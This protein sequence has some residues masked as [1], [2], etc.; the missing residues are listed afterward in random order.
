MDLEVCEEH[1][2]LIRKFEEYC[3]SDFLSLDGIKC[4][5]EF[6][7]PHHLLYGSNYLHRV[8]L[9]R[10]VTLEMVQYIVTARSFAAS[11]ICDIDDK[12]ISE[13]YPLHSA[14]L[15][16]HCPNSVVELFI[17]RR[18]EGRYELAQECIICWDRNLSK[19]EQLTLGVGH[20]LPL[21]L[22]L[23]RTKNISFNVVKS[24]VTAVPDSLLMCERRKQS[25]MHICMMNSNIRDMFDIVKYLDEMNPVLFST[26]DLLCRYPLHLACKNGNISVEMIQYIIDKWPEG[27]SAY[28]RDHWLPLHY[29]CDS[30]SMSRNKDSVE[31]LK[32]MLS[33]YPEGA[34]QQP[35]DNRDLPFHLAVSS[36][37]LE[38]CN[39]FARAHPEA[40]SKL[41][42]DYHNLPLHCACYHRGNLDVIK[43]LHGLYPQS[44]RIANAEDDLPLHCACH[45]GD[46]NL[47]KFLHSIYP[48]SI[49]MTNEYY[50][51]LPFHR[52]CQF[53]N[54]LKVIEYLHQLY[55]E[56]VNMSVDGNLPIHLMFYDGEMNHSKMKTLKFLLIHDPDGA[57][58]PDEEGCLP[59]HLACDSY[60]GFM[61]RIV[62]E[63]VEYLFDIHPEALLERN[64]DGKLPID[65]ARERAIRP[66]D[67]EIVVFLSTQQNYATTANNAIEMTTPDNDG[68][69]PLHRAL[70]NNAPLGAI[71]LLVNSNPDAIHVS[72]N[73]G[74]LP[75]QMACKSCSV[76]VVSYLN[77]LVGDEW[78]S[79]CDDKGNYLLHHACC[80]GNVD[81]VKYI[82]KE[83]QIVLVS[84]KNKDEKLPIHLFNEFVKGRRNKKNDIKYV[85]TIWHLLLAD[86]E[87]LED[88]FVAG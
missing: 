8:C 75:I 39:T 78:W 76:G 88:Y 1:I 35:N 40:V 41:D 19:E 21:D 7:V 66:H 56:A 84:E 64:R 79:I 44:I 29:L 86:P 34:M 73:N 83:G 32:I 24:M 48:E 3:S 28:D 53:N 33:A 74:L 38:F 87:T 81:V 63:M 57:L 42:N 47:I 43:F 67:D 54:R 72:D 51:D 60:S 11:T 16:A 70:Q 80:G 36:K 55:P 22:Y 26:A 45:N 9:N 30:D 10:K 17:N 82:L 37:S 2:T 27:A 15:N 77:N 12:D 69:L 65:F 62:K 20:A 18:Y 59:L 4:A 68:W 71:K 13:A 58:K 46:V 50:R 14:C 25:P 5:L 49:R 23:S 52:A 61:D 31:V 85:E 6:L